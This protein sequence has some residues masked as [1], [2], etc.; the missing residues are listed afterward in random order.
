MNTIE[1]KKTAICPHCGNDEFFV[2]ES[3]T[4]VA[5]FRRERNAIIPEIEYVKDNWYES[6]H[7]M[8][9]GREVDILRMLSVDGE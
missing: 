9:C 1:I 8:Q 3:K 5:K 2:L 4:E 7:C 6:L